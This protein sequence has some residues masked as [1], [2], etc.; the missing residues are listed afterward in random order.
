[1]SYVKTRYLVFKYSVDH[2]VTDNDE[3]WREVRR[4]EDAMVASIPATRWDGD[5][6][7]YELVDDPETDEIDGR[8]IFNLT[9]ELAIAPEGPRFELVKAELLE[10]LRIAFG[11]KLRV[12]S[13]ELQAEVVSFETTQLRI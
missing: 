4:L 13:V 9:V 7:L 6:V 8:V 12:E 1:M 11:D 2:F 10:R 5:D 3:S